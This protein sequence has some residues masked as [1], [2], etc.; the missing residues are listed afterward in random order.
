MRVL[1]VGG[2]EVLQEVDDRLSDV[3]EY[4]TL[5]HDAYLHNGASAS[6]VHNHLDNCLNICFGVYYAT[7]PAADKR[8]AD[9]VGVADVIVEF[10][11]N[12]MQHLCGKKTR[13]V[14]LDSGSYKITDITVC[15]DDTKTE[16][17]NSSNQ[18]GLPTGSI[19]LGA[20]KHVKKIKE[21]EDL[22]DF[23]TDSVDVPKKTSKKDK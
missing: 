9:K 3:L 2:P 15:V 11:T 10:D 4:K 14:R 23:G 7:Y 1:I 5:P 21:V 19:D 6:C 18:S 20:I 12:V 17:K 8:W 16:I 13:Y 22:I